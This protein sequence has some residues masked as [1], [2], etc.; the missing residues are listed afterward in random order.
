MKTIQMPENVEELRNVLIHDDVV[1]HLT[2][3]DLDY[4]LK[5]GNFSSDRLSI[6]NIMNLIESQ[7]RESGIV[8]TWN[9]G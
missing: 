6:V 2:F 4:E 5:G 8:I 1:L 9:S 7:F 3:S